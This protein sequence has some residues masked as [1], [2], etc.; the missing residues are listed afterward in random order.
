MYPHYSEI[1]YPH[2]FYPPVFLLMVSLIM[3][4][5]PQLRENKC[6]RSMYSESV[7]QNTSYSCHCYKWFYIMKK[8]SSNPDQINLPLTS[9]FSLPVIIV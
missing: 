9:I 6:F 8:C 3:T 2:L 1:R 7:Y 4:A 5:F